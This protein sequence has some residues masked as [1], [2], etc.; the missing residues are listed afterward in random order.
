MRCLKKGVEE[1]EFITFFSCCA[2]PITY[3]RLHLQPKNKPCQAVRWLGQTRPECSVRTPGQPR[4]EEWRWS[5]TC[6]HTQDELKRHQ[7]PTCKCW[8][9]KALRE[10][11]ETSWISWSWP[12]IHRQQQ[13]IDTL[14]FCSILK[15]CAC[16]DTIN[17]VKRQSPEW[18]EIVGMCVFGKDL[19]SR[20]LRLGAVG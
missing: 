4:A 7:R 2:F 16:K 11:G 20:G 17:R 8:N 14:D 15:F 13:K 18:E 6:H 5:L 3:W 12:Q 1:M 19:M 9:Y 10:Q